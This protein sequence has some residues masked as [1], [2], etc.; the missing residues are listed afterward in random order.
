M[1]PIILS[2]DCVEHDP[3]D[4]WIPDDV[5]DVDLYIN[6]TIGTD[7]TAGDNFLLRVV[8]P[9]NLQGQNAS[10]H[11]I[12]IHE[13]SFINVMQKVEDIL[14]QCQG[15][16]WQEISEKLAKFMSWEFDGYQLR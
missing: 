10:Q 3:I 1:I 9:N 6:F 7:N 14:Q 8:T 5:Y 11:S 13:Y 15:S 16:H 2:Y 4:N 12:V